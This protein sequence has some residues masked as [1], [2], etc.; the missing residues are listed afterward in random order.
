MDTTCNPTLKKLY[1][2][3]IQG[4]EISFRFQINNYAFDYGMIYY[5]RIVAHF[6]NT[7]IRCSDDT[8]NSVIYVLLRVNMIL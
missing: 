7:N 1:N 8:G 4:Y 2:L 3:T 6:N 5:D